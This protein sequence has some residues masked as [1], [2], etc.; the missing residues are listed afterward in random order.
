MKKIRLTGLLV[1]GIF[2]SFLLS[3]LKCKK[4]QTVT[5]TTQTDTLFRYNRVASVGD[6]VYIHYKECVMFK[7]NGND[8]FRVCV[9]H[10]KDMRCP[11]YKCDLCAGQSN[12]AYI[13][14]EI[15][16]PGTF[17]I[18]ITPSIASCRMPVCDSTYY[19]D[20]LGYRF[21][22]VSLLPRDAGIVVDT[23]DYNVRV[24]VKKL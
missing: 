6:S 14:L 18:K 8:A 15:T 4:E 1:L 20:T 10:I 19:V 12:P 5:T 9:T 11:L 2:T 22:I 13:H 21:C 7:E 3:A 16:L 17:P 23:T 24:W